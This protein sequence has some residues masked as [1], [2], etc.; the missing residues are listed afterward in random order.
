MTLQTDWDKFFI[1][2]RL[3][4]NRVH[5][6]VFPIGPKQTEVVIRNSLEY[7]SGSGEALADSGSEGQWLPSP[8]VTNE[9]AAIVKNSRIQLQNTARRAD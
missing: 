1:D 5:L 6:S 4:R 8:D 3:F 7:F 9:V 2:G